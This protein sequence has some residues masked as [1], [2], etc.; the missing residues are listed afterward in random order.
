MAHNY[1]QLATHLGAEFTV[2]T[3]ERR[4]RGGSGPQGNEYSILSEVEDLRAVMGATGTTD[5]FGHSYGGFIA[6][7]AARSEPRIRKIVVYEPSVSLN[8]SLDLS[9]L[10]EFDAA[11]QAGRVVKATVIFLKKARLSV[12]CSWPTPVLYALSVLLLS[13]KSGREMRGLMPNTS[14]EVREVQRADSDGAEFRAI[15]AETLLI[16]GENGAAAILQILP[17]LQKIIPRASYTLLP[18]L[19][20]N[21]PDLGPV[22]AIATAIARH[23]HG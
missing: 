5:L 9:W 11:F 22:P 12:V 13:G 17:A 6:L 1:A 21:G 15:N 3:I 23:F 19:N 18:G 8:G 2:H 7:Q 16:G 4:G 10:P 14:A 20:H